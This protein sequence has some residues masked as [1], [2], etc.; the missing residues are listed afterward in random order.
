MQGT[1]YRVKEVNNG[2]STSYRLGL[3]RTYVPKDYP[4]YGWLPKL[5]C[6]P[7]NEVTP[8]E[9]LKTLLSL[10]ECETPSPAGVYV[11][12]SKYEDC[13]SEVQYVGQSVV[14]E[15]RLRKHLEGIEVSRALIDGKLNPDVLWPVPMMYK[16]LCEMQMKGHV[17]YFEK[18]NVPYVVYNDCYRYDRAN[19]LQPGTTLGEVLTVLEQ[20]LMDRLNPK[21]NAEIAKPTKMGKRRNGT[22]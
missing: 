11:I 14:L 15:T 12:H 18:F 19:R 17:V 7:S 13:P 9:S 22:I 4:I 16:E 2:N 8:G 20:F 5:K 21:L 1:L 6:N 3:R 10:T